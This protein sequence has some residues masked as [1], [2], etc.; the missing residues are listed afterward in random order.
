M[1]FPAFIQVA[2]R[3]LRRIAKGHS[4]RLIFFYIPLVVFPLLALIYQKGALREIPVAIWDQDHTSLSRTVAEYVNASPTLKVTDYLSS[5]DNPKTYFSTHEAHAI[6]RIP[7]GLQRDVLKGKSTHIQVFTNSANIIFGNIILREAYTITGT[8]NGGILLRKWE[9]SGKTP[10][11]A[12][13]L[14]MPIRVHTQSLF[15]PHYNYL[16]YL[17]PGLLTVLLQ[18]I[19]FF[20]A[21]RSFNTEI[22][23]GSFDD[24]MQ[25]ARGSALNMLA[26]KSL[27][28]LIM[29]LY[30]TGLIVLIFWIFG[31]P[32]RAKEGELLLLFAYFILTNIFLG[33]MLSTTISDEILSLDAAFLYNSPAFVFSGFT[34]PI[35]AMTAFSSTV[36]QF[37]PYTHFLHAFFKLYQ[38]GT[39]FAY[40][41]PDFYKL[42]IFLLVGFITSYVALRIR[43]KSMVSPQK[44]TA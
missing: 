29:G 28:Q 35:F 43:I 10:Q 4:Q 32:F 6:I 34:F 31:I 7:K 18:M 26:G 37:I 38:L 13:L 2:F 42:T 3:E 9:A 25:T 12:M 15:N 19:V 33:F 27:A 21:T 36:A 39:P 40:T 14:V 44:T 8:I 17:V 23:T 1:K 41:L 24:L 5:S 20:V 16:Y 30:V 22:N 11:Q